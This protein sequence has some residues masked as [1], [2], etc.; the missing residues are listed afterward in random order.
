MYIYTVARLEYIRMYR[1]IIA[2]MLH[3]TL[4]CFYHFRNIIKY[5]L[6]HLLILCCVIFSSALIGMI[7][8]VNLVINVLNSI[9]NWK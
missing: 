9:S 2:H 4:C 7:S 6:N 3:G 8:F 5:N 1:I